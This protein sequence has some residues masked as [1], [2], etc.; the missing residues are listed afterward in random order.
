MIDVFFVTFSLLLLRV[1]GPSWLSFS[2]I[3]LVLLEFTFV[4]GVM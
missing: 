3:F 1:G 2:L 4:Y